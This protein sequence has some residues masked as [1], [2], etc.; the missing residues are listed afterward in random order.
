M[1]T[2]LIVYCSQHVRTAGFALDCKTFGK[3][4]AFSEAGSASSVPASAA[5]F[6][7]AQNVGSC[8][9]EPEQ[10]RAVQTDQTALDFM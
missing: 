3:L 2:K 9:D 7:F 6:A 5:V 1:L 8:P 10:R 4:H